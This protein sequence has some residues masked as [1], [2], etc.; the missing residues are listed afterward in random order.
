MDPLSAIIGAL[1]AGATAAA[2]GVASDAVKEAYQGLKTVLVDVYKLVSTPLLEKKPSSPAARQ[3]VEEELKDNPAVADDQAVLEKVKAL[4]DALREAAPAQ[5]A[6]WSIDIK[7]LEAG[8]N[9]IAERIAGG[10]RGEKWKAEKDIK[11]SD[12][13]GGSSG[14]R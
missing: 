2:S 10:I 8:G 5:L 3:A 6:A 1:I 4:Q 7:E 9:I 12:V 14:K 11:I 13:G